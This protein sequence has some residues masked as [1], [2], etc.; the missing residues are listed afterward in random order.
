MKTIEERAKQI[1]V[2]TFCSMCPKRVY[3]T[4]IWRHNTDRSQPKCGISEYRGLIKDAYHAAI[5]QLQEQHEE[6][7]RW[8]DLKEELPELLTPVL[9]K[10]SDSQNTYYKI[11]YRHEY[12]NEDGRYRWTDSEGRPIYVD[13]WREIHE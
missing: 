12:D 7:T 11:V 6:L 8:H 4:C 9:G 1:C 2:D 5:V 10:Q 3:T 13:G